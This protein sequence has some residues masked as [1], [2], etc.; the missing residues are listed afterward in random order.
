M[1]A[2]ASEEPSM[3]EQRLHIIAQPP[4]ADGRLVAIDPASAGW[5]D[6]SFA[7]RRLD[8][9]QRLTIGHAAH[10][11]GVVVLDGHITVIGGDARWSAIGRRDVFSGLP[12]AIYIPPGHHVEVIAE[13]TVQLGIAWC[14][15]AAGDDLALRLISPAEIAVEVRGGGNATRQINH[16]MPAGFP[17]RRLLLVEVYTPAGNWSSYPPH[18]HDVHDPPH[19]VALEEIYYYRIAAP[20][21]YALQ[22]ITSPAHGVDRLIRAR[23]GDLVLI[24]WGYHPVVAPPGYDVYY[25][26]AL[27]GSAHAMTAADDPRY[28]WVRECWPAPDPRVPLVR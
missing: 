5:S 13:T 8:A 2:S 28:A 10:E 6:L 27:A 4:A 7:A 26:N 23:D 3:T 24:P 21:G 15:A 19:E 17:A 9:G 20:E 22:Q 18:K 14:P 11:T 16:I 12:F 1:S 25:L